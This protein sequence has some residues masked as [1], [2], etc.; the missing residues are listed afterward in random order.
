MKSKRTSPKT[1]RERFEN[2]VAHYYRGVC[3]FA[4]RL[5]NDPVEAV[6]LT[7][8]AFTSER[9]LLRTRDEVRV[10]T[11]LLTAVMRAAQLARLRRVNWATRVHPITPVTEP[12]NQADRRS[13]RRC[14]ISLKDG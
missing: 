14:P 9:K 12:K 5:T 2:L 4:Y 7:H 11:I 8:A 13:W 3:T 10:V 1:R 6:L